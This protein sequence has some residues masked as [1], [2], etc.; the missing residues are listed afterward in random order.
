MLEAWER[1]IYQDGGVE[2]GAIP[3]DSSKCQYYG[4]VECEILNSHLATEDMGYTH[5][6]VVS[7]WCNVVRGE[8]VGFEQNWISGQWRVCIYRVTKNEVSRGRPW[9]KSSVLTKLKHVH[10]V[11]EKEFSRP[12][13]RTICFSPAF[14]FRATSSS[15]RCRQRLSYDALEPTLARFSHVR[16][17]ELRWKKASVSTRH[18]QSESEWKYDDKTTFNTT[19]FKY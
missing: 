9:G 12:L 17:S 7:H 11:Q 3:N 6:M 18:G 15:V 5:F 4:R 10:A 19:H 14:T 1:Q 8:H 16:V 2:R 13:N